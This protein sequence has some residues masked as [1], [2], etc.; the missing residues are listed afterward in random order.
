MCPCHILTW[1]YKDRADPQASQKTNDNAHVGDCKACQHRKGHPYHN[2]EYPAQGFW[3]LGL[4]A[5]R[6]AYNQVI[7]HYPE[8]L[9]GDL[10]RF[11][12]RHFEKLQELVF[13][14]GILQ[15]KQINSNSIG[16]L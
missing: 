9:Y 1:E 11:N 4:C 3:T 5:D 15:A 8:S 16:P 14:N 10:H 7:Q 13:S 12:N 6:V 2:V